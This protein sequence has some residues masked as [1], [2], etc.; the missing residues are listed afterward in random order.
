MKQSP[1]REP[2]PDAEPRDGGLGVVSLDADQ[3]LH[4][5][6]FTGRDIGGIGWRSPF[7]SPLVTTA[8]S[9]PAIVLTPRPIQSP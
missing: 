5:C 6:T 2:R 4:V 3:T 9:Q 8:L 1:E 7:V